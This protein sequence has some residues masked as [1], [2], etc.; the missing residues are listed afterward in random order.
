LRA[1]RREWRA[2]EARAMVAAARAAGAASAE[3][4]IGSSQND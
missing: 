4:Q 3:P 1:K 2:A